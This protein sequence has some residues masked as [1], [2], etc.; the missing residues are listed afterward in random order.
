MAEH[1]KT[2]DLKGTGSHVDFAVRL[3]QPF[4][5]PNKFFFVFSRCGP[6]GQVYFHTHAGQTSLLPQLTTVTA[7]VAKLAFRH[8]GTSQTAAAHDATTIISKWDFLTSPSPSI[9]Q[10]L[11][12]CHDHTTSLYL[13]GLTEAR[14]GQQDMDSHRDC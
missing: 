14:A 10:S 3:L 11:S 1:P 9:G 2:G 7:R 8:P 13:G 4:C 6:S 5:L 12:S